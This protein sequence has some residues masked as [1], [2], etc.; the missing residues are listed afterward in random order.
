MTIKDQKN[1]LSGNVINIS[2]P[3]QC[4]VYFFLCISVRNLNEVAHEQNCF[5]WSDY[6]D[7]GHES[8]QWKNIKNIVE[9]IFPLKQYNANLFGV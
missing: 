2:I 9:K 1:L 5:L 6:Q 3:R 8:H 4:R 7:P